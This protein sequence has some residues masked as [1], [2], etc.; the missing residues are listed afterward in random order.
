MNFYLKNVGKTI[1]QQIRPIVMTK[2]KQLFEGKMWENAEDIIEYAD[3][4]AN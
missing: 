1:A 3:T 4:E 2:I